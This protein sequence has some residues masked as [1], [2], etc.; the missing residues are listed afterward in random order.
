MQREPPPS[1][2]RRALATFDAENRLK[3]RDVTGGQ[4]TYTYDAGGTL[5]K[6]VNAD[7]SWTVYIGGVYEKNSDG[8][9]VGMTDSSGSVLS[10]QKYWPYG[11]AR[12]GSVSPVVMGRRCAGG[13][14]R[15]RAWSR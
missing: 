13:W 10:T 8:S 9:T 4:D 2:C 1:A 14:R 15:R 11:A 12:S 7:G 5:V 3:T 6:R